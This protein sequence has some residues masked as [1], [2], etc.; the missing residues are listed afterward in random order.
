MNKLINLKSLYEQING[1]EADFIPGIFYDKR[2]YKIIGHT[3]KIDTLE[4]EV[5]KL[6]AIVAELVDYV[7]KNQ[8][9][10]L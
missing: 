1:A 2:V 6:K 3:Q 5:T 8:E 7:Y 4:R 9:E 10:E